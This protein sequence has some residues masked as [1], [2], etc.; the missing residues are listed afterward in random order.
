[1]SEPFALKFTKVA[2]EQ[3]DLL[4][5]DGHLEKKHRKVQRTLGRLQIDPSHP[6]LN[7]HKYTSMAGPNGEEVWDSYVENKTPS[8]WRVFWHYGPGSRVITI[9]SI[10]PHP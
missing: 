8:A 2:R 1:V 5:N 6:G 4:R 7:S 9:L 3:L 10:T